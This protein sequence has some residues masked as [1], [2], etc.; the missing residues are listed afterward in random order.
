VS[1]GWVRWSKRRG[2][3]SIVYPSTHTS[4]P[5]WCREATCPKNH[6][7]IYTNRHG[8][9]GHINVVHHKYG[10]YKGPQVIPLA[11]QMIKMFGL[12]EQANATITPKV[13][14]EGK[15]GGCVQV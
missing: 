7:Y 10:K 12:L 3:A 14:G 4:T 9:N 13:G 8:T 15:V 11:P 2:H 6:V 1:E 5:P